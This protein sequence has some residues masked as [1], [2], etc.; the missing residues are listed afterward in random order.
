MESKNAELRRIEASVEGLK[1]ENVGVRAALG[2]AEQEEAKQREATASLKV[3][4]RRSRGCAVGGAGWVWA[5]FRS[6]GWARCAADDQRFCP[7]TTR[8]GS[9]VGN[10]ERA[11][12][13]F[14]P[15]GQRVIWLTR[16]PVAV[17]QLQ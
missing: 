15:T 3:G 1:K 12:L 11:A 14:F 4:C 13:I 7:R 8:A 9:F 2:R 5:R 16:A 17:V 10:K 6:W